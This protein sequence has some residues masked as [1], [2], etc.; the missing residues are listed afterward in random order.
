MPRKESSRKGKGQN[1]TGAGQAHHCWDWSMEQALLWDTPSEQ[2]WKG[3]ISLAAGLQ[4]L[5]KLGDQSTGHSKG[6]HREHGPSGRHDERSDRGMQDT[7]VQQQIGGHETTPALC[8]CEC[9]GIGWETTSRYTS[10][11]R[12]SHG[13]KTS[14]MLCP[15]CHHTHQAHLVFLKSWRT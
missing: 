10:L 8:Q 11:H 7:M 3:L 4:K 9:F 1:Q 5:G 6:V 2:W 12:R 15:P 13:N 14:A